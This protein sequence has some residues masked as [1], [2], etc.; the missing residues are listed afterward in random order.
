MGEFSEV[1]TPMLPEGK[2]A[3]DVI[4]ELSRRD[5]IRRDGNEWVIFRTPKNPFVGFL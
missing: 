3:W 1:V 4:R 2:T 5:L